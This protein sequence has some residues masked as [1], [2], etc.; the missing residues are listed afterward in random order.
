MSRFELFLV[1]PNKINRFEDRWL[2]IEPSPDLDAPTLWNHND[3]SHGFPPFKN[4]R[5]VYCGLVEMLTAYGPIPLSSLLNSENFRAAGWGVVMPTAP[6]L[7]STLSNQRMTGVGE[8]EMGMAGQ[9]S[10]PPFDLQEEI[11]PEGRSP[12]VIHFSFCI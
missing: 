7:S 6:P 1:L 8:E 3:V 2:V 4:V 11:T 9:S 12:F 10:Y 5:G